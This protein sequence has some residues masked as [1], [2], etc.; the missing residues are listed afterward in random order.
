M[1]HLKAVILVLLLTG[2]IAEAKNESKG[3]NNL[4]GIYNRETSTWIIPPRYNQAWIISSATGKGAEYYACESNGRYALFSPSGIRKTAFAFSFVDT[5]HVND[6]FKVTQNERYGLVDIEGNVVLPVEYRS[7]NLQ[8]NGDIITTDK[9]YI[10]DTLNASELMA[11]KQ[12][13]PLSGNKYS[14]DRD[15][16]EWALKISEYVP[17][18]EEKPRRI[19]EN[20]NTSHFTV[21]DLSS[22]T[23]GHCINGF[24]TVRDLEEGCTYVFDKNCKLLSKSET[25]L[26][27]VIFSKSGTALIENNTGSV[28]LIR[29]D[30]SVL[31]RF[32]KI[33]AFSS[34]IE[35][36]GALLTYDNDFFM[37]DS[38]GEILVKARCRN[39]SSQET[40]MTD[41]SGKVRKDELLGALDW[42]PMVGRIGIHPEREG[43]RI[44]AVK[45]NYNKTYGFVDRMFSVVIPAKFHEA[46]DFSEGLAAVAIKD[47]NGLKWGFIDKTGSFV[48][49]PKFSIEPGDFKDGYALVQKKN[50]LFCYIDRTGNIVKQGFKYATSFFG[51]YAFV[52][53][54]SYKNMV[55]DTSFNLI[56]FTPLSYNSCHPEGVLYYDGIWSPSGKLL[57]SESSV[58]S[59]GMEIYE[60]ASDVYP[61]WDGGKK[62]YANLK[63]EWVLVFNEEEF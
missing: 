8:Y 13:A 16:D 10:A 36:I 28:S 58:T 63:G 59:T 27:S 55:V 40:L 26:P 29:A 19:E 37:I 18:P 4:K 3:L 2:N 7:I 47:G 35:D 61:C 6:I 53:S 32:E 33:M 1:K 41:V 54:L 11:M 25:F 42:N 30:G 14:Y 43:L 56:G 31:K 62:G 52:R 23:M 44:Y 20:G 50:G 57:V 12:R 17:G 60:S 38:A 39:S 9:D 24:F 51:G 5:K 22:I 48:I 21:R 46:H 49:N 34:M 45:S 15:V